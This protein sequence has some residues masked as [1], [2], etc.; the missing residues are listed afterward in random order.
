MLKYKNMA[1]L[2]KTA[3]KRVGLS[4]G[5]LAEKLGFDSG[6]FISNIERGICALPPKYFKIASEVLDIYI[7]DLADR[8]IDDIV[9]RL[10]KEIGRSEEIA[11]D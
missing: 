1:K 11:N 3:R 6:Q 9:D 4:Q 2:M 8:Y 5:D 10:W 7:D